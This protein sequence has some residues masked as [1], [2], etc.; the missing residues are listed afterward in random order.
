[1]L[2]DVYLNGRKL[3]TVWYNESCDEWWVRTSLIEYDGYNPNIKVC[4]HKSK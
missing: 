4:R 2:W 1:M 3:H